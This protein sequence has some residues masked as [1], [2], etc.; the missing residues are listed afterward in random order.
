MVKRPRVPE[1]ESPLESLTDKV[2]RTFLGQSMSEEEYRQACAN[3]ARYF[4]ILREWRDN[5]GDL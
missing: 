3:L 1:L 5:H 4:S 2:P